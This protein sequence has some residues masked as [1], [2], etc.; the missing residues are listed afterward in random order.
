MFLA[1][2]YSPDRPVVCRLGVLVAIEAGET[3]QFAPDEGTHNEIVVIRFCKIP[4]RPLDSA[5]LEL[6]GGFSKSLRLTLKAFQ[7]QTEKCV[8]ILLGQ[9]A[10]L[11]GIG[12]GHG[13]NEI[14]AGDGSLAGSVRF[15]A[16]RAQVD[17]ELFS[18][19]V[20]MTALQAECLR[21]IGNVV[22]TALELGDDDF[23]LEALHAIC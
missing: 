19:L 4:E 22:V 2:I 20:E 13:E 8:C 1:Y 14:L 15:L 21:G 16:Q 12:V 3:G 23:T 11:Y 6:L 5:S 17:S 9:T 10:N 18:F 7:A